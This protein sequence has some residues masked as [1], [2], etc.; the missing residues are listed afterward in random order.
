MNDW[1]KGGKKH[2]I[3]A[4]QVLITAQL[5]WRMH[6]GCIEDAWRMHGGCIEDAWRMH[7]GCMEDAWRMHGRCIE[8][9]LRDV[10]KKHLNT[11]TP[12]RLE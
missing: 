5:T 11:S 12:L 6:R 7:G 8:N 9:A 4:L 2:L 3:E 1:W 10:T